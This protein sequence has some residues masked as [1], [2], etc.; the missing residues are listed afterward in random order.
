MTYRILLDGVDVTPKFL[1]PPS[2]QS[3]EHEVATHDMAKISENTFSAQQSAFHTQLHY[4]TVRAEH[5]FLSQHGTAITITG[6]T[7]HIDLQEAPFHAYASEEDIVNQYSK[8]S[9]NL[10]PLVINESLPQKINLT[11]TETP[12]IYLFELTSTIEPTGTPESKDVSRDNE[13][14][15]FITKGKGRNRKVVNAESQTSV[16]IVKTRSTNIIRSK[17]MHSD[18]F[19]SGWDMLDSRKVIPVKEVDEIVQIDPIAEEQRLKDMLNDVPIITNDYETQMRRIHALQSFKIATM[20]MERILDAN[21]FK[22]E[23]TRIRGLFPPNPFE[24]EI[25][26]KYRLDLL[27]V[28]TN[29]HVLNRPICMIVLNPKNEDIIA[30]GYGKFLFKEGKKGAVCIWNIKN[31]SQPERFYKFSVPVTAVAFGKSNPNLLTVSFYDGTLKVIDITHIDVKL[32]AYTTRYTSNSVGPILYV[33]WVQIGESI[34]DERIMSVDECGRVTLYRI[35]STQELTGIC[36]MHVNR[37]EGKLKGISQ[38]KPCTQYPIPIS[39][40]AAV[41]CFT[42][43]PYDPALYMVGTNMGTVH[44]C[45]KYF[46]NQ[47]ID[48]FLAHNGPVYQIKYSPFCDRIFLTCGA[49]SAIRL[50]SDNVYEPLVTLTVPFFPIQMACWNPCH[51]TIIA[52][53]AESSVYIWDIRKKTYLP[54]SVTPSP[55]SA[56][57]TTIA[58]TTTGR[59]V[60]IGDAEGKIHLFTLENV[61][62]PPFYQSDV[63]IHCIKMALV[64]RPDVIR[65]LKKKWTEFEKMIALYDDKGKMG[66]V[67]FD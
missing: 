16:I 60:M 39:V 38:L 6:A 57:L 30:V 25:E 24:E 28:F 11:L 43:V 65:L 64:T 50:W 55:S 17:Q 12:I 49:D 51:S 1:T 61:P 58:F 52:G 54:A 46:L 33:D 47:H 67:V 63:L 45:S 32:V 44:K 56:R 21:I 20:I 29:D 8:T 5:N 34:N 7:S 4:Q 15:D 66:G 42:D 9:L 14:Y 3:E 62:F 23:Q 2:V 53:V 10:P 18:A 35:G 26:F 19:A 36:I 59:N 27:W 41:E 31:P 13:L 48:V 40:Y 37:L 22:K